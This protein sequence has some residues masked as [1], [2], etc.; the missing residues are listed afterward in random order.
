MIKLLQKLSLYILRKTNY[1]FKIDYKVYPILKDDVGLH[2][3]T[4]SDF[5]YTKNINYKTEPETFNKNYVSISYRTIIDTRETKPLEH[6]KCIYDI[7]DLK[8]KKDL[9]KLITF[10]EQQRKDLINSLKVII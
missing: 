1:K 10:Y 7:N 8:K 4:R 2:E 6:K 9:E 5:F 3:I